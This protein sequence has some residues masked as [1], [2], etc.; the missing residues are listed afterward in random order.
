MEDLLC[1]DNM[2]WSV[3]Q[4]PTE[5]VDSAGSFLGEVERAVR[6]IRESLDLCVREAVLLQ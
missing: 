5:A 6:A 1:D 2:A 4:Y 3:L